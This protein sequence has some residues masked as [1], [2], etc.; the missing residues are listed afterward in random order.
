MNIKDRA[1]HFSKWIETNY[2]DLEDLTWATL[3]S[4]Y[5]I[6]RESNADVKIFNYIEEVNDPE[7]IEAYN[8]FATQYYGFNRFI[9]GKWEEKF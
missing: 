3:L 1:K 9:N 6:L 8:K 5:E 4:L 2:W 7:V